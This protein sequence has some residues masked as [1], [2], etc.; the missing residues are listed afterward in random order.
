MP[1]PLYFL[2]I[3][4]YI[5]FF[6]VFQKVFF[7]GTIYWSFPIF[8]MVPDIFLDIHVYKGFYLNSGFSVRG[9]I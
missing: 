8:G 2:N 5:A 1:P 6:G 9:R 7:F 4:D 3:F